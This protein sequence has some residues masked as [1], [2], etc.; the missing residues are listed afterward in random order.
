MKFT[1]ASILTL[2]A[3]LAAARICGETDIAIGINL[4][5][6]PIAVANDCGVIDWLPGRVHNP[7]EFCRLP[8]GGSWSLDCEGG[9]R[10]TTAT[11]TKAGATDVYKC[12]YGKVNGCVTYDIS[13][14]CAYQHPQ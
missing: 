4:K 7:T 9:D 13:Y 1:T 10:I 2:L 12:Q 5:N 6:E 14:C 3:P 11:H 8:G